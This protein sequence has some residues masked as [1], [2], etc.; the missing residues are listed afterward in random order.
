[1]TRDPAR[2][3][4]MMF[5]NKKHD[6]A[7]K[8]QEG[9]R[10]LSRSVSRLLTLSRS[11]LRSGSYLGAEAHGGGCH[12]RD[13]RSRD[14]GD[15]RSAVESDHEHIEH[16]KVD[17]RTTLDA[18]ER[19]LALETAA[20]FD[21]VKSMQAWFSEVESQGEARFHELE[22]GQVSTE[23]AFKSMH[24]R[25]SGFGRWRNQRDE[26][27]THQYEYVFAR[28]DELRSDFIKRQEYID[29]PR[30]FQEPVPPSR[31][32]TKKSSPRHLHSCARA[33]N[34]SDKSQGS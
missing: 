17:I 19:K 3:I 7:S 8:F 30:K 28:L 22:E 10:H 29:K 6:M 2:E 26:G 5:S 32:W 15:L 1:M 11:F 18:I 9:A 13:S 4:S 33:S 23:S 27:R 34:M 12:R 31:L 20:C 14:A 25:L 21:T 24:A 16:F